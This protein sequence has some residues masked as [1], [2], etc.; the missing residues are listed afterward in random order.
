MNGC[1]MSQS[2]ERGS[3]LVEIL[4]V[5]LVLA[6][7][8]LSISSLFPASSRVIRAGGEDTLLIGDARAELEELREQRYVD[9]V[10]GGSLEDPLQNYSTVIDHGQGRQV[11]VLWKI[12]A[13][14]AGAMKQ[15]SI[16]SIPL[17]GKGLTNGRPR[18]V[19]LA[20]FVTPNPNDPS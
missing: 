17:K 2:A 15:L 18:E 16:R 8:L 20:T 11:M 14:G 3:S 1:S 13:A 19:Q 4:V 6:G 10:I 9:L 12:E 5:L 7:V